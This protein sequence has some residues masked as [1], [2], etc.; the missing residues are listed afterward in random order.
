M[1]SQTTVLRCQP[2]FV[3]TRAARKMLIAPSAAST[4]QY[5]PIGHKVLRASSAS[6]DATPN[7]AQVAEIIIEYSLTATHLVEVDLLAICKPLYLVDDLDLSLQSRGRVILQ[8]G[9]Q[10]VDDANLKL[11]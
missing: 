8:T 3:T 6:N 9:F 5:G 4:Y 11:I 7:G 1:T 10:L 2:V